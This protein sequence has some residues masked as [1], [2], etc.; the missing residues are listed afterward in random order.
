[1]KNLG[2][3]LL[4]LILSVFVGLLATKVILS[5]ST[6]F[7]LTFLAE[8]GFLKLYGLMSICGV[9]LY[10]NKDSED[11]GSEDEK[12]AKFFKRIGNEAFIYLVFWGLSFFMYLVISNFGA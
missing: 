1:M 4:A 2:L 11:E 12:V 7:G 3:M 6:L 9:I 8:L 5:I 10:K